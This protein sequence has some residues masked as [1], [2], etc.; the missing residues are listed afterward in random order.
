MKSVLHLDSLLDYKPACRRQVQRIQELGLQ[1][2][3]TISRI[4]TFKEHIREN[5]GYM[6]NCLFIGVMRHFKK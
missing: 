3:V 6:S 1:I 2:S 5:R 4:Y